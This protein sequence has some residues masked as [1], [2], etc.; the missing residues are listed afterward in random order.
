MSQPWGPPLIRLDSEHR[1]MSLKSDRPTMHHSYSIKL[2]VNIVLRCLH[3]HRCRH[4]KQYME[5]QIAEMHEHLA[6]HAQ[7]EHRREH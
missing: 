5:P 2:H 1:L 6:Q 4:L 7:S 3:C